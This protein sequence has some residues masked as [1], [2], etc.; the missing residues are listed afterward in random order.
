MSALHSFEKIIHLQLENRDPTLENRD[1]TLK[2]H[3]ILLENETISKAYFVT[4]Y[5]IYL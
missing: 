5:I 4:T 1:P 2:K 3:G